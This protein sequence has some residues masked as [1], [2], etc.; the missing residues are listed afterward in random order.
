MNV[1]VITGVLGFA[2]G[3]FAQ[4]VLNKDFTDIVIGIDKVTYVSNLGLLQMYEDIGRIAGVHSRVVFGQY[5]INDVEHINDC[6]FFINFAA[7]THVDVSI[8]SQAPFINNNV[9]GVVNILEKIRQKPKHLRPLFV[10]ISTDEVYGDLSNETMAK[11]TGFL[12]SDK[13]NPSNPYAASK[14]M[15]DTYIEAYCKTFGIEYVIIR[16]TNMYG[17]NQYPEKLIPKTLQC[18]TREKK[19]PLYGNGFQS[20][21]W[22][23]VDDACKGIYLLLQQIQNGKAEKNKIYHISG[24][25]TLANISVINTIVRNYTGENLADSECAKKYCV[26]VDNR[27]SEDRL[28]FLNDS[29]FRK[30]T[31]FTEERQFDEAI[32]DIVLYEKDNISFRV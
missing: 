11:L 19:I 6:D 17:R 32:E 2:G 1:Y 13:L 25:T 18:L 20:R 27:P 21:T 16:L 14:A 24:T 3:H 29:E 28:Y 22:L 4:L 5:D 23:H 26:N 10:Q 9:N 12:P 30:Q 15:A 7:S 31:G 8:S